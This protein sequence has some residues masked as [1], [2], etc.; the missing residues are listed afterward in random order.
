MV[1]MLFWI[2]LSISI[3]SSFACDMTESAVL[4]RARIR[5]ESNDLS[6]FTNV[7]NVKNAFSEAQFDNT[8]ISVH[9]KYSYGA[10]TKAVARFPEFCGGTLDECKKELA[11][12]FG[13]MTQE[14]GDGSSWKSTFT[15]HT[16]SSPEHD[17]IKTDCATCSVY[18]AVSGQKYI[19]RGAKQLSWNYQYGLYSQIM[20]GD[21]DTLLNDP[22]KILESDHIITSAIW[23]YMTPQS[24]KPSMHDI[25]LGCWTPDSDSLNLNEQFAWTT[26]VINGEVECPTQGDSRAESRFKFFIKW[27]EFFGIKTEN[28]AD[29]FVFYD[30]KDLGEFGSKISDL[31]LYWRMDNTFTPSCGCELNRDVTAFPRYQLASQ[32]D[33]IGGL[34]FCEKT[35][36]GGVTGGTVECRSG[37]KEFT[38]EGCGK[39]LFLGGVT[40]CGSSWADANG[41]CGRRCGDNQHCP[42][43]ETCQAGMNQWGAGVDCQISTTTD[44]MAA[45]TYGGS[46][47]CGISWSDANAKCGVS[48][49]DDSDC[50]TGESCMGGMNIWSG[51]PLDC[52]PSRRKI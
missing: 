35:N 40:R 48:C 43:G 11:F 28:N 42:D 29:E 27:A 10:L 23:F 34:E 18:P 9:N 16:E 39:E 30:C 3:P 7:N 15:F 37:I 13:H 21:K 47:R 25:V 31:N 32:S 36:C 17:Y 41:K 26:K 51:I 8:L 6:Q 4:E 52:T 5:S 44:T 33:S 50:P 24:P 19:G 38:E 12:V 49:E 14:T 46:V 1:S 20:T 22:E 2:F 45:V